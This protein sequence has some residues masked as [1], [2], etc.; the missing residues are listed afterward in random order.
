M[1]D[2]DHD[3]HRYLVGG[4]VRDQLLG[5][6]V[7]DRDWVVVGATPELMIARGF[8]PVGK[9]FPVFLHPVTHEE[10]AL[11]RTERKIRP[12]YRGFHVVAAP[13]VTLDD[14]LRRRDLTINALAQAMDGSVIDPFNGVSDLRNRILRHISTAFAE[15]PVRVL[16]VARF[17]ARYA[18]LGFRVAEETRALM[19][20]MVRCGEV[21][22][23]VPERI[24]AELESAL[25]EPR[26]SKFIEILRDCGALARIFPEIDI[27]FGIPQPARYHPEIDTGLHTMLTVDAAARS[28][29]STCSRFAALVHDLGKG[30]TPREQWPTH[31][32]H[33]RT[34]LEP[35]RALGARLRAPKEFVRFAVS[36]CEHHLKMHRLETL[37]PTTVLRMLESIDGLHHPQ[38]LTDFVDACRADTRGR[39][40]RDT[41]PYP[42][43]HLLRR[44]RDG[45]LAIDCPAGLI[46]S[47]IGDEIRRRRLAT[48]AELLGR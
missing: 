27:L 3:L 21:D 43:A 8:L 26:P 33:E 18:D 30:L 25:G 36:V 46:G 9:E 5:I 39:T 35:I 13:D 16:R 31:R 12:G 44:C 42:Q 14:D 4:A 19:Q 29:A 22:A 32:G 28:G 45:A 38:R 34:G 41:Q 11:A 47:A 24:W 6:E 10:Y 1:S 23:L 17:A 37:K 7:K 48:I 15:D 20:G 2:A 40:G